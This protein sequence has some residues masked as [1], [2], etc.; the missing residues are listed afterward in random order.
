MQLLDLIPDDT[1][2]VGVVQKPVGVVQTPVG[3]VQTPVGVV[4]TPVGVVQNQKSLPAPVMAILS[5]DPVFITPEHVTATTPTRPDLLRKRAD[6][7]KGWN[8]KYLKR[9]RVAGT[10]SDTPL[11]DALDPRKKKQEADPP[12]KWVQ[13]PTPSQLPNYWEDIGGPSVFFY[14]DANIQHHSDCLTEPEGV[15]MSEAR[16]GD[17]PLPIFPTYETESFSDMMK[18]L[19]VLSVEVVNRANYA[20]ILQMMQHFRWKY[21]NKVSSETYKNAL[22]QQSD[23]MYDILMAKGLGSHDS[24][25]RM[26]HYMN[27]VEMRLIKY[28]YWWD[29]ETSYLCMS[30]YA[31]SASKYCLPTSMIPYESNQYIPFITGFSPAISQFERVISEMF[32]SLGSMSNVIYC[33]TA[34]TEKSGVKWAFYRLASKSDGVLLW[35]LDYMLENTTTDICR[36][37]NDYARMKILAQN[38]KI[39]TTTAFLPASDN[40]S[41]GEKYDCLNAQETYVLTQSILQTSSLLRMYVQKYCTYFPGPLDKFNRTKE[42]MTER[43]YWTAIVDDEG[44]VLKSMRSIYSNITTRDMM[45]TATKDYY[46]RMGKRECYDF[47]A[48]DHNAIKVRRNEAISYSRHGNYR[49]TKGYFPG[50]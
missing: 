32:S 15:W 35:K 9:I 39:Y 5:T 45:E 17:P 49:P 3:V 25:M 24:H 7:P 29:F 18:I 16:I 40:P 43:K 13:P 50:G 11:L 19:T 20:P 27:G 6:R 33:P 21:I 48:M 34:V 2:P 42:S 37:V 30:Q 12:A 46:M 44:E 47:Y 36:F 41:Y 14:D 10:S 8:D 28:M 23:H 1:Q 22:E 26:R 31:E 38:D 4:Q